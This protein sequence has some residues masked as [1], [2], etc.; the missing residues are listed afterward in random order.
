MVLL[1]RKR[2]KDTNTLTGGEPIL[3]VA[4]SVHHSI[5]TIATRDIDLVTF[6]SLRTGGD[7]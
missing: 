3:L 2:P 1:G 4:S 5:T 7:V 6:G